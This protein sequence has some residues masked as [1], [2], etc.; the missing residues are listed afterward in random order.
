[1]KLLPNGS[2]PRL[3]CLIVR[4]LLKRALAKSARLSIGRLSPS[5][6]YDV[7]R[8]QERWPDKATPR[9][10][11]VTD[12]GTPLLIGTVATEILV[13]EIGDD[14]AAMTAIGCFLVTALLLGFQ[15]I[16]SYQPGH[17]M[18]SESSCRPARRSVSRY[19]LFQRIRLDN[20]IPKSSATCMIVRPLVSVSRTASRLISSVNLRRSHLPIG[21]SCCV[22]RYQKVPLLFR[23]KST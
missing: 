1:M 16:F 17:A 9:R 2:P 12:V 19:C 8:D 4:Y 11:D 22:K 21:S 15:A 18:S 14:R 20:P 23:G 13:E 7:S 5:R 6:R 10:P 3:P